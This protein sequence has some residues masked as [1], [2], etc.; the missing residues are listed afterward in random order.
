MTKGT[1]HSVIRRLPV[2]A[3]VAILAGFLLLTWS[4]TG[5]G[6]PWEPAEK[7]QLPAVVRNLH[8]VEILSWSW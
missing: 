8:I 2:V 5:P 6:I 3:C 7:G 4:A 1:V